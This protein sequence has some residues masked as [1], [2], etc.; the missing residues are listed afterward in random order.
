MKRIGYFFSDVFWMASVIGTAFATWKLI[1]YRR[2]EPVENTNRSG[3]GSIGMPAG[4]RDKTSIASEDTTD[5]RQ[6]KN[7]AKSHDK[8][9]RPLK[10]T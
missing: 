2:M 10:T 7:P 9:R 1:S 6:S 8:K 4:K 3:D 5:D